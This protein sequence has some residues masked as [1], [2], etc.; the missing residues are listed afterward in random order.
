VI[1]KLFISFKKP[2]PTKDSKMT[3][4]IKQTTSQAAQTNNQAQFAPLNSSALA[5]SFTPALIAAKPAN[6]KALTE[7]KPYALPYNGGELNAKMQIF[8]RSSGLFGLFKESYVKCTIRGENGKDVVFETPVDKFPPNNDTL[9]AI[10]RTAYKNGNLPSSLYKTPSQVLAARKKPKASITPE[11]VNGFERNSLF[12]GVSITSGVSNFFAGAGQWVADNNFMGLND[13]GQHIAAQNPEFQKAQ[14]KQGYNPSLAATQFGEGVGEALTGGIVLSLGGE[15]MGATKIVQ[16]GPKLISSVASPIVKIGAKVVKP[17]LAP[18]AKALKPAA[19]LL[20]KPSVQKIVVKTV[21]TA[22]KIA[23]GGIKYGLQYG[24][25]AAD[26]IKLGADIQAKNY[27]DIGR[28]IAFLPFTVLPMLHGAPRAAKPLAKSLAKT[29]ALEGQLVLG[30][31]LKQPRK[32]I[33]VKPSLAGQVSLKNPI[34]RAVVAA[35]LFA[36]TAQ[37][38]AGNASG[39]VKASPIAPPHDPHAKTRAQQVEQQRQQQ[40]A[41]QSQQQQSQQPQ[42]QQQGPRNNNK[43]ANILNTGLKISNKKLNPTITQTNSI[44]LWNQKLQVVLVKSDVKQALAGTK[45]KLLEYQPAEVDALYKSSLAEKNSATRFIASEGGFSESVSQ[46]SAPQQG[47]SVKY[48]FALAKG[49][50]VKQAFDTHPGPRHVFMINNSSTPAHYYVA[51]NLKS[52]VTASTPA[53]KFILPPHSVTEILMPPN[54]R[55]TFGAVNGEN[56]L[57]VSYH[58]TDYQDALKRGIDPNGL[59][60]MDELSFPV[61]EQ[62]K[63]LLKFKSVVLGDAGNLSA[64]SASGGVKASPLAVAHDPHAKTRAQQTEQQRQQQ[65]A[66]QSQ[67]QQSQQPQMQQQGPENVNKPN[68]NIKPKASGS[69]IGD[70]LWGVKTTEKQRLKILKNLPEA[71]GL[72]ES[73]LLEIVKCP[74]ATGSY[75]SY[76]NANQHHGLRF[77]WSRLDFE[78]ISNLTQPNITEIAK[79][80]NISMEDATLFYQRT[81]A[82][83]INIKNKLHISGYDVAQSMALM[84]TKNQRKIDIDIESVWSHYNSIKTKLVALTPEWRMMHDKWGQSLG[85]IEANMHVIQVNM[86]PIARKE[87]GA[88]IAEIDRIVDADPVL[89][90][91]KTINDTKIKI[92]NDVRNG[93]S[94]RDAAFEYQCSNLDWLAQEAGL[95]AFDLPPFERLMS[96]LSIAGRSAIG[97]KIYKHMPKINE[98]FAKDAYY[99]GAALR[100]KKMEAFYHV[101]AK[102][103]TPEEALSIIKAN[104]VTRVSATMT[105]DLNTVFELSKEDKEILPHLIEKCIEQDQVIESP[106]ASPLVG[107]VKKFLTEK[108]HKNAIRDLMMIAAGGSDMKALRTHLFTSGY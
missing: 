99:T 9:K 19:N 66:Q 36:P 12:S 28:D 103:Q 85:D 55:H 22:P 46:M 58:T 21:K 35:P 98:L 92:F 7:L 8:E 97:K 84:N 31:T 16:W 86:S 49:K 70:A 39:G 107:M 18:V 96:G 87:I 45:I 43:P 79:K 62:D 10:T 63:R 102:G 57:G 93:H 1:Y 83:I 41:Q 30:T 42:M 108:Y 94:V 80:S 64:S 95:S 48:I 33:R 52:P 53:I 91:P 14:A 54:V 61:P 6:E 11:K 26:L 40:I 88:K 2:T 105:R 68:D 76:L 90:A 56:L 51:G 38:N 89:N 65:I 44:Q 60:M 25:P 50:N 34:V 29:T 67:Q 82:S 37:P 3:P 47:H 73:Y 69:Q 75:V 15:I 24:L 20:A 78:S 17:I 100:A 72:D 106:A 74:H 13:A 71:R 59:N 27:K 23:L 104:D 81:C 101:R 32:I 4:S 5:S 77:V